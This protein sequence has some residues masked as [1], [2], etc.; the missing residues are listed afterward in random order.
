MEEYSPQHGVNVRLDLGVGKTAL[1]FD[2][3]RMRQVMVN[4]LDNACQ[5]ITE[6]ESEP[7][8]TGTVTL[9]TAI[10]EG[11]YEITVADTGCGIANDVLDRIFEPL[12][13]TKGFGAGLGLPLVKRLVEQHGG[14]IRVATEVGV[15]TSFCVSLPTE[16][17]GKV[18]A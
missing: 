10:A 7:N 13:S 12:F 15:G 8:P 6:N 4:L 17:A 3:D 14:A 5:A 2:A 9:S 11:R 1:A 18:A 16:H